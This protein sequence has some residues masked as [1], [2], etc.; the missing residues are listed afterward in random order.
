MEYIWVAEMSCQD[1]LEGI[2]ICPSYGAQSTKYYGLSL[3]LQLLIAV[4]TQ[5]RREKEKTGLFK[6]PRQLVYEW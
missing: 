3:E 5:K 2:G 6:I 1:V 4:L